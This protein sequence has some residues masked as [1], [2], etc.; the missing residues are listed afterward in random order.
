MIRKWTLRV[1]KFFVSLKIKNFKRLFRYIKNNGV[2][3]M[4]QKIRYNISIALTPP[5]GLEYQAYLKNNAYSKKG[6]YSQRK[7]KNKSIKF[8]IV[9]SNIENIEN[10]TYDNYEVVKTLNEAKGDYIVFLGE[11]NILHDFALFEIARA[12][13]IRN[14]DVLYTDNDYTDENGNRYNPDFKSDF[15]IDSL[16]AKNYIGDVIVAKAD[17]LKDVEYKNVYQTILALLEKTKDFYHIERVHYTSKLSEE[18][19]DVNQ[20]IKDLNEYFERTN[21]K[22]KATTCEF[23]NIHKVDY[24]ILDNSKKVSIVIPN[25]DHIDDLDKCVQSIL[26]STYQNYE[27]VIV[28]NNSRN[29]ETFEYYEKIKKLD[30]RIKVIKL[31]INGFNYSRIVNFGVENSTGDYIVMLNNDVELTAFDWLESMIMYCQ[32]EDVGIVGAKLLFEDDTVQHAGVTLGIRGL[33]GHKFREISVN[34]FD[35]YD[36]INYVQEL[37]AVTAACFMVKKSDYVKVDN[38]DEKL[39]VAFNDVDFCLKIRKEGLKIIYNPFVTGYHYESKSR[40]TDTTKEK[41]KR[42]E[43]EFHLFT[44]R[45]NKELAMGD[46]FYN[47]NYFLDSDIPTVNYNNRI[48]FYVK[49][50]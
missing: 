4:G 48:N 29:K 43:G 15:A 46:P 33:A 45:W 9:T 50:R 3:G 11:E 14:P 12:I 38:F 32:R 28:E 27:I 7:Y 24:E 44:S 23:K 6:L 17:L 13:E 39:A 47:K 16:L 25:M 20:E 19:H 10:Q 8:S 18:K 31:E 37:S 30:E 40:G 49:E 1:K 41:Q 5:K 34:D 2:K 22:A 26:K 42:F 36:K 21:T 35:K